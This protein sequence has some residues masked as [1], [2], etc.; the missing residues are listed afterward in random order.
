VREL[1]NAVFDLLTMDRMPWWWTR[2][3]GGEKRVWGVG[4]GVG[5]YSFVGNWVPEVSCLELF[6]CLPL[7]WFWFWLVSDDVLG[8][9]E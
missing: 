9:C 5:L 8:N 4:S 2:I 3:G 6:R 7:V 1:H